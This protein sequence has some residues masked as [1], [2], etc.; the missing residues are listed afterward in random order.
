M[1][2]PA[3]TPVFSS[4]IGYPTHHLRAI[5]YTK[6]GCANFS[7]I[8]ARRWHRRRERL[9]PPI[10]PPNARRC[11]RPIRA[12]SRRSVG[13]YPEEFVAKMKARGIA[14][15]ATATTVAEARAAVAVGADVIVAQGAEAGGHRG[16]FN[17]AE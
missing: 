13:L 7:G 3:A 16:A 14:W 11:L 1:C 12:S 17:A 15:W 5:R 2:G 4:I 6:R 8:G 9:P 10:S